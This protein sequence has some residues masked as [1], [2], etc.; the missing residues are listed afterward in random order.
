MAARTPRTLL[1]GQLIRLF[2]LADASRA[3]GAPPA[4]ELLDLGR[5]MSRRDFLRV[6]AAGA[7]ALA[8]ARVP[9]GYRNQEMLPRIAI[10]GAG[11]AGLNTAYQLQKMGIPAVVY[12]AS[13]RV[14]G[15]MFTAQDVM[16]DGL[17]TELGGEF[18]N[19]DHEDMLALVD[20]LGFD[21]IDTAA[22]DLAALSQLDYFY[23]G[24]PLSHAELIEAYTPFAERIS[25]DFFYLEENY[26]EVYAEY[27]A[28]SIT[29]YLNEVGMT[30]LIRAVIETAFTYENG[31][32][33]SSQSLLNFMYLRPAFDGELYE[34]ISGSDERYKVQGGNQR[35][36]LGLTAA[37]EAEVEL[38]Y[39]LEAVRRTASGFRLAF[40][41]DGGAREIQAD[42]VVLAIPLTVLR[43]VEMNADLPDA[44]LTAVRTMGYGTSSKVMAGLTRRPW[45]DRGSIG[46]SI[47]DL[48]FAGSWDNALGQP[49]DAAG[50]TFFAGGMEA[51]TFG[52]GTPREAAERLLPHFER[53]YP[54]AQAAY[55]GRAA[56][57][58]W[59]THPYTLAGYSSLQ[60]GQADYPR[61]LSAPYDGLL[62][63]G[64]HTSPDHWGYMNGAAESGRRSAE[65]IA[66]MIGAMG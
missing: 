20:E 40:E 2:R 11:I 38:G 58:H 65:S 39:R 63:A 51:L 42:M 28:L 24:R 36:P 17:Y 8:A 46:Y 10:V 19:S 18:I 50:V 23:D 64:E 3:E 32:P 48:P 52:E 45:R 37:L 66:E 44:V 26:D 4:R 62:F 54:G 61:L 60:P 5:G 56:R 27:D 57:M 53:L 6:S 31:S 30:G 59:A 22:P 34:A 7:G 15:R 16:G 35:I 9:F 49:V 41:T 12:E 13:A 55:N 47:T 29:D 25:T 43:Q 14:G 1:L 33:A 21:L